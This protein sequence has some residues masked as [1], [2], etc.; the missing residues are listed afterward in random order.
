MTTLKAGTYIFV[1]HDKAA[2]HNFHL[3]GPGPKSTRFDP[4]L[5]GLGYT[6][7]KTYEGKKAIKL[8]P[9]M[10]HYVLR[11]ALFRDEGQLQGHSLTR[12]DQLRMGSP[13]FVYR[14]GPARAASC[15]RPACA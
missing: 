14:C 7:T 1:I 10:W 6:G 5:S 15:S 11:P 4:V 13:P 12:M 3:I 2:I 8:T 9:G